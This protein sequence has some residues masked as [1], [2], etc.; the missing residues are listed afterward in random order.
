MQINKSN[1]I[2]ITSFWILN[3]VGKTRGA[4][5]RY[6]GHMK[7]ILEMIGARGRK[8]THLIYNK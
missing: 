1:C 2:R 8:Y 7:K 3:L 5:L 4:K 6:F